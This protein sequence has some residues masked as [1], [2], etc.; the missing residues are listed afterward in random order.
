MGATVLIVSQT[1]DYCMMS[2][3]YLEAM[4]VW[5][6]SL[7][8]TTGCSV[9]GA[10]L[11]AFPIPLDWDRPW[12]VSVMRLMQYCNANWSQKF[13]SKGIDSV[14][15]AVSHLCSRKKTVLIILWL[16]CP[17]LAHFLYPWG[18]YWISDWPPCCSRLDPLA[19]QTAHLQAQV[20]KRTQS[21]ATR[22]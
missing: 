5:D 13:Q 22:N 7:Q 19:S 21:Q 10:W 14:E 8:I 4:S 9:I 11:G 3:L 6:T 18:N 12:Q 17:G 20:R 1:G 2:T 15:F 16:L